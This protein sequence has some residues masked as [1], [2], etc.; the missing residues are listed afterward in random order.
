MNKQYGWKHY[1]TVGIGLLIIL[2]VHIFLM[3]LQHQ[4]MTQRK[5]SDLPARLS[6]QL[7]K[8]K[9]KNIRVLIKTRGFSNLAHSIVKLKAKSGLLVTAN[10]QTIQVPPEENFI[11]EPD[12][13]L[14]QNGEIKI[15]PLVA[16]DKIKIT[17]LKRGY[18]TPAYRGIM[19]LYS[20]SEGIII[21]NELSVEEYL[22][23]VVPSEMPASYHQEALKCQAIC[24]RSYAYSQMK[25]YAYPTYRAH[26]DDST[27]YQVY[28]NSKERETTIEAVN[29]TKGLTVKHKGDTVITY[30]FSTSSGHTTSVEA[31]GTKLTKKNKYLSGSAICDESGVDYEKDYP[32]YR[33][34]ICIS[35]AELTNLLELNTGVELGEL[36]GLAITKRGEGDIALQMEV[37]GSEGNLSVETENK[38]RKA[39]GGTTYEIVKQDGSVSVGTEL[40]PSA[41]IDI[42]FENDVCHIKGGG[43]G[44]GIGMSQNGANEMAKSGKNYKEIL[45]VFYP[46]SDVA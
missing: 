11:C 22:Y 14:F 42:F 35:K 37:V 32:W 7:P 28:G 6:E 36:K 10:N 20:T 13:E 43:F 15:V 12:N 8:E 27:S 4:K 3:N 9:E 16:K 34:S 19:E 26:V 18:G 21:I 30:Y 39:L 2:F 24:A 38:I 5:E 40:L 45:S 29:A 46:G 17:N 23:G 1:V 41:F 25:Q 44:H 33:W 31:W